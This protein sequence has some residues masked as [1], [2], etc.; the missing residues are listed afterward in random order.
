MYN[1]FGAISSQHEATII[2]SRFAPNYTAY[3]RW[4]RCGRIVTVNVYTGGVYSKIAVGEII[5]TGLP[6]PIGSSFPK[7]ILNWAG[8]N[9]DADAIYYIDNLG[10]LL[11]MGGSSY[12]DTVIYGEGSFMY[13]TSDD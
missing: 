13:V 7:A 8:R 6:K 5:F 1:A 10:N 4:W 12:T 11:V 2:P 3:C 9:S